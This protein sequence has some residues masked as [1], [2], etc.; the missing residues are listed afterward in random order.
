M[1]KDYSKIVESY[2]T[3]FILRL[4]HTLFQNYF[5]KKFYFLQFL[6]YY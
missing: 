4:Y 6:Y 2:K 5:E 3:Y 1:M